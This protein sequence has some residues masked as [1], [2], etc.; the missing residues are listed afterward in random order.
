[1]NELVYSTVMQTGET[2][3]MRLIAKLCSFVEELPF[4]RINLTQDIDKNTQC[5]KMFLERLG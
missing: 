5:L 4:Y 1:M 2:Q 3:D